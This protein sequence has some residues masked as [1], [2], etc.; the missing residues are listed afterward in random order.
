[1]GLHA[2]KTQ[3]RDLT[4][5][6]LAACERPAP[7][8]VQLY[9]TNAPVP[10]GCPDSLLEV[11]H[12]QAFQ[13]AGNAFGRPT[14]EAG[15]G[16]PAAV[17]LIIRLWRCWPTVTG[18]GLPAT[19]DTDAASEG[20]D[21]DLECIWAALAQ[22]VCTGAVSITPPA[23]VEVPV[24]DPVV[25]PLTTPGCKEIALADTKP[26]APRG[27]RAGFEIRL[28]AGWRPA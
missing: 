21:A 7:E 26:L 18:D 25:F 11:H 17:E 10:P 5:A 6:A 13:A 14:L 16:N 27:G 19:V 28:V 9:Q 1:M 12:N 22:A 2:L 15:F 20:L 4:L 23:T 8:R 3:A 24:P